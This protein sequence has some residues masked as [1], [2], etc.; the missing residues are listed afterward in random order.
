MWGAFL[1]T[2]NEATH[3]L[4]MKTLKN[5]MVHEVCEYLGDEAIAQSVQVPKWKACINRDREK[6]ACRDDRRRL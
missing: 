3:N 2:A 1:L 5:R 4:R 6:T